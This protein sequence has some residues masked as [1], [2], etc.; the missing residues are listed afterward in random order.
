MIRPVGI[1]S[2]RL[3]AG[4][5]F[6]PLPRYPSIVAYLA[7]LILHRYATLGLLTASGYPVVEMGVM[8]SVPGDASNVVPIAA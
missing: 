3:P 8:V 4:V 6:R 1:P 7:R 5:I 2:G